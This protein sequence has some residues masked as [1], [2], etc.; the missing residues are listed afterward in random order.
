MFEERRQVEQEAR[1]AKLEK[2]DSNNPYQKVLETERK[3]RLSKL[4]EFEEAPYD[5]DDMF[6]PTDKK[7]GEIKMVVLSGG[8]TSSQN[9]VVD[10]APEEAI[11]IDLTPKSDVIE[12]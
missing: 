1:M 11:K 5:V 8:S 2:V 3:Q 10:N 6:D 12:V 9:A 4:K 7:E